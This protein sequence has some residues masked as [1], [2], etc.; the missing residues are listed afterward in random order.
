MSSRLKG[1]YISLVLASKGGGSIFGGVASVLG[2]LFSEK[3]RT[4]HMRIRSRFHPKVRSG[5]VRSGQA[6][7]GQRQRWGQVSVN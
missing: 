1:H 7:I 2:K 3:Q 4:M 6:G 5:Q